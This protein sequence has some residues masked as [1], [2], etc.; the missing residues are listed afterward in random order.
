MNLIS[1]IL[2]PLACVLFVGFAFGLAWVI[3]RMSP[4]TNPADSASTPLDE[5]QVVSL[6]EDT[7]TKNPKKFVPYVLSPLAQALLVYLVSLIL[8]LLMPIGLDYGMLFLYAVIF[9]FTGFSAISPI[10]NLFLPRWWLNTGLFIISWFLLFYGIMETMIWRFG[11]STD[12]TGL[13]MAFALPM[14]A[15]GFAFPLTALVRLI[16]Y[17][18]K[19]R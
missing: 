5:N 9:I 2:L 16:M 15:A 8:I 6:R 17:V 1:I 7:Q 10:V 19:N 13:G 12:M 4:H 11:G 14:M 18:T 3:N